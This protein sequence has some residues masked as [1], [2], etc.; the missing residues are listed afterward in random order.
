VTTPREQKAEFGECFDHERD[1][2][3]ATKSVCMLN[4]KGCAEYRRDAL[5]GVYGPKEQR[6]FEV[7]TAS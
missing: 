1:Q 3:A 5:R 2:C 4:A 6:H 7:W